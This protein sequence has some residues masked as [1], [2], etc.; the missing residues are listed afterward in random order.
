MQSAG[1]IAVLAN[2]TQYA[3][4]LRLDVCRRRGGLNWRLCLCLCLFRS[5]HRIDDRTE[6]LNENK[7]N[8]SKSDIITQCICLFVCALQFDFVFDCIGQD[9]VKPNLAS[10][11]RRLFK[12]SYIASY[13]KPCQMIIKFLMKSCKIIDYS[14]KEIYLEDVTYRKAVLSALV[15][16]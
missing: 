2:K 3:E 11:P 7:Q 16:I 4:F 9:L 15:K 14:E 8:S 13:S 5:N 1:A 10:N 12:L 6:I